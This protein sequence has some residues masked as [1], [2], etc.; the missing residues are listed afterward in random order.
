MVVLNLGSGW[1]WADEGDTALLASNIVKFG[2]PKACH[3]ITFTDSDFGTRENDQLVT[4]SSPWLQ[5][6]LAA[7][8]FLF[9][10][11]N[12]FTTRP[13]FALA[14]PLW[15]ER[16]FFFCRPVAEANRMVNG[17][18]PF[19]ESI[20]KVLAIQ[21]RSSSHRAPGNETRNVLEPFCREKA[22]SAIAADHVYICWLH[23]FASARSNGRRRD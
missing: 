12:T 21:I 6:Y 4:V 2:V 22:Y 1:L 18:N 23:R 17:R 8:S 14:W 5:Y 15:S 7:G 11:E 20:M 9:F 13:P 3:G 16:D 19:P 10:G